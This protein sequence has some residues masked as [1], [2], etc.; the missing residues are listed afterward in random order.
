MS[1]KRKKIVATIIFLTAIVVASLAFFF[2]KQLIHFFNQHFRNKES[3][4]ERKT[5]DGNSNEQDQK[6]PIKIV[7]ITPE[8]KQKESEKEKE[9][10]R[11]L[12]KQIKEIRLDKIPRKYQDLLKTVKEKNNEGKENFSDTNANKN[13]IVSLQKRLQALIEEWER[14]KQTL[15]ETKINPKEKEI[16]KKNTEINAKKSEIY[17]K[18][19]ELVTNKNTFDIQTGSL[20]QNR[21]EIFVKQQEIS[22]KETKINNLKSQQITNVDSLLGN[23]EAETNKIRQGA[24]DKNRQFENSINDLNKEI[25]FLKKQKTDKENYITNDLNPNIIILQGKNTTLENEFNKLNSDKLILKQTKQQLEQELE[26]LKAELAKLEDEIK[27]FTHL[28]DKY[29]PEVKNYIKDNI[30]DN[31]QLLTV[32]EMQP[33]LLNRDDHNKLQQKTNDTNSADIKKI[34]SFVEK[35]I[36]IEKLKNDLQEIL[37]E[38]NVLVN[39][40]LLLNLKKTATH[41]LKKAE[42][43][44]HNPFV[45]DIENDYSNNTIPGEILQLNLLLNVVDN[46]LPKG[47]ETFKWRQEALK[48]EAN[49][50]QGTINP[51][52]LTIQKI[53]SSSTVKNGA[54]NIFNPKNID[55]Q[56]EEYL[57]YDQSQQYARFLDELTDYNDFQEKQKE[58]KYYPFLTRQEMFQIAEDMLKKTDQKDKKNFETKFKESFSNDVSKQT[59]DFDDFFNNFKNDQ[60]LEDTW[61]SNFTNNNETTTKLEF[62]LMK[63]KNLLLDEIQDPQQTNIKEFLQNTEIIERLNI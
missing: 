62:P 13:A 15:I 10:Y 4:L 58:N 60:T 5:G 54:Q 31:N 32:K 44:A 35:L 40:K 39:H 3:S 41:R 8:E 11:E 53:I 21:Y 38:R 22:T 24:R 19:Q 33:E 43:I 20:S 17:Y 16:D 57:N 23:T 50:N 47:D 51:D 55:H 59:L 56:D 34:I 7:A 63:N 27:D 26:Q 42:Q 46:H 45:N 61:T 9:T 1:K 25:T 48:R 37:L 28:K 2:R 18:N 49:Q 14:K 12:V 29:L 6:K 30:N 36:K 52:W